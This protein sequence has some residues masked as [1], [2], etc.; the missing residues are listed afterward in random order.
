MTVENRFANGASSDPSFTGRESDAKRAAPE[1]DND[2]SG[3]DRG[4][5]A[6]DRL[7]DQIRQL[8]EQF[9]VLLATKIDSIKLTA[10]RAA[11]ACVRAA[12]ASRPR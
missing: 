8:R 11:I 4:P 1:H 5:A 12:I 3:A 9:V 2:A 10:R 7:V 6:F